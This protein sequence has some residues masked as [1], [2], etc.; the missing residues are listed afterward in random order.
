MENLFNS[1]FSENMNVGTFFVMMLVSLLTGVIISFLISFKMKS[2]KRFFISNAIM[3][4]IVAMVICF[5]NGNI[6]VA[7]AVGGAFGLVRFRSAQGTAE[8]IGSLFISVASGIAFG[9]GYIAYGVIF[10]VLLSLIYVGL[11]YLPI[12]TH[13][14]QS[15]YKIVK[16]TIS[17]DL[18]YE[19]EFD[20]LFKK[21]GKEYEYI[22]VRTSD[23]G[24]LYKLDVKIKMN[25]VKDV[26]KLLDEI[27]I[28]NGNLEV[29]ALSYN[30]F[31]SQL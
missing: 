1:I 25:D 8:E 16:I 13:K 19:E 29:S 15:Q 11:N 12:F 22:K 4:T 2:S 10:A 27:R 18:N 7:V 17:E 28:R 24:S 9:M 5:A 31:A 26:K 23:M 21:Y 14:E 20:E 3:P 30:E 6:G